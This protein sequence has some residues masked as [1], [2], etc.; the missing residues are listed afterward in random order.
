MQCL[1]FGTDLTL[2]QTICKTISWFQ[3]E[4]DNEW[5][6]KVETP[7]WM[8][9]QIKGNHILWTRCEAQKMKN[10]DWWISKSINVFQAIIKILTWSDPDLKKLDDSKMI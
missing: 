6:E 8:K 1:R 3:G 4:I 7:F 10:Y 9:A 2:I 5:K